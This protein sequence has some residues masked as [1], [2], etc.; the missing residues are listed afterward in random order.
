MNA[1]KFI[2]IICWLV[3]NSR[4]SLDTQNLQQ[5]ITDTVWANTKIRMQRWKAEL[6][7]LESN[8]KADI[9]TR[10][11]DYESHWLEFFKLSDEIILSE[12]LTRVFTAGVACKSG[13]P[14][15][16]DV[17]QDILKDSIEIKKR[18]LQISKNAPTTMKAQTDKTNELRVL[19]DHL[20][21]LMLSQLPNLEAAKSF[22]TNEAA[23]EQFANCAGTY[24][25]DVIRQA[26]VALGVSFAEGINQ[27]ANPTTINED[28]NQKIA[29]D[30][31]NLFPNPLVE[32][33]L[34]INQQVA[35]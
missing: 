23:F 17:M 11:S 28:I 4:E 15:V 18:V 16:N 1:S 12:S 22:A 14:D 33:P 26:N 13:C 2:H 9:F 5:Q 20:V 25:A 29:T 21:N 35:V 19:N 8:L 34:S 27:I 31:A 7:R 32:F 10:S 24:Q 3:Q 6:G 30:I